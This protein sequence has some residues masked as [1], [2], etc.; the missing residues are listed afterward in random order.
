[1]ITAWTYGEDHAMQNSA[2]GTVKRRAL[3][4]WEE[5]MLTERQA[6]ALLRVF[7]QINDWEYLKGVEKTAFR[8]GVKKIAKAWG[9]RKDA[10]A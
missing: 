2:R 7:A 6:A 10:R 4:Q 3:E 1:M 9:N 8:Q 5:E